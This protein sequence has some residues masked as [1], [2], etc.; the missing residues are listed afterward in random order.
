MA[1]ALVAAGLMDL[2]ILRAR[3][4]IWEFP[5]GAVITAMI[6]AMVLRVQEPWYV[7]AITSVFAVL[8]KYVV[9]HGRRM[10]LIPRRWGFWSVFMCSTLARTD[11]APWRTWI[12]L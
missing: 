5:R 4:R 2:L 1:R 10:C 8:T 7:I 6:V 3:K 9:R 11:G 12:R